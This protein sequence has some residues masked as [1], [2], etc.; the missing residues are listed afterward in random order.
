MRRGSVALVT[1]I[2][3]AHLQLVFRARENVRVRGSS[4]PVPGYLA[5]IADDD[6]VTKG[7]G[8]ERSRARPTRTPPRPTTRPPKTDIPRQATVPEAAP[9][10]QAFPAIVTHGPRPPLFQVGDRVAE[11]YE[12]RSLLGE[13]G[14]G[15]VF[16]ALDVRLD[17]VVAIK[18]IWP[19][20]NVPALQQEARALAAFRHPSLVTVH[21][22]ATHEDIDFMVL[23]RIY[24]MDLAR[25]IKTRR[26]AHET[27][28]VLEV[29]EVVAELAGGLAIVHRAGLAHRDVKPANV[30][31]TPDH[32]VV[33]MDFGLVS[34]STQ[35]EVP[36]VVGSPPYMAPEAMLGRVAPKGA[37]LSD[38]FALGVMTYEMLVG[39]RP[40]PG[41]TLEEVMASHASLTS[42][43]LRD[44]RRDAPR[45]FD[46]LLREML[47]FDPR[48]RPQGTE[49]LALQL[50]NLAKG[51][52]KNVLTDRR[53]LLPRDT[54]PTPMHL[55]TD[56][57]L[58][59]EVEQFKPLD[60]LI[61]EDDDAIAKLLVFYVKKVTNSE[62]VLR[63]AGDGIEALSKIRARE[64]DL[65]LLDIHMPR[66]TGVEVCM[67]LRSERL[68][69]DA[70]IVSVS[71]GAQEHDLQLL[72]QLGMHHFVQKGGDMRGRL[73]K[74][75]HEL[76]PHHCEA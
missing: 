32:R 6:R 68:A 13:G 72:H 45:A 48:D 34:D 52:R 43:R 54:R 59:V 67:R 71:A 7:P 51:L 8:G 11:Q 25:H 38:I 33:L 21:T 30:M 26:D 50:T 2:A 58:G 35:T 29:I 27:F 63:R 5:P 57:E 16:E 3:T 23:E 9:P 20:E 4:G 19:D 15:Q 69:D 40:F 74:V 39:E 56:E 75:I 64:P 44:S 62:C 61:V 76:F 24:G 66:M 55:P 22:L 53:S 65:I 12:I 1:Q 14:M 37:R 18:A 46:T 49:A 42:P 28:G 17:R 47:A 73:G 60:V 41:S 31:L 36:M 10:S 70:K